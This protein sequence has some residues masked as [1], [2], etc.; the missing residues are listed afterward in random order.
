MSRAETEP[1]PSTC[2]CL[3][4]IGNRVH[5]FGL[6][7]VLYQPTPEF[8][9]NLRKAREVC[10]D[11]IAVDNTPQPDQRLHDSLR[12]AGV[13][14]I[15]NRNAGGLAGA[16]NRGAEALLE[17]GRDVMFLLDQDSDIDESFFDR[18]MSACEAIGA[19]A[20]LVGPT[21]YEKGMDT[22]MPVTPPQGVDPG[23]AP[24]AD[25]AATQ[26]I[27]SSGTAMSAEA[28][29]TLGPFREDY[30]IECVDIEYGLRAWSLGVPV[31]MTSAVTLNQSTGHITRH[32]RHFTTNH[33]AWRR[34]YSVRNTVHATRTY[35]PRPH[36]PTVPLRMAL[37]QVHHVVRFEDDKVRKLTAICWGWIDGMRSRLGSFEERHPKVH[38]FCR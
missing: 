8:V 4:L 11:V 13:E 23:E 24:A 15:V 19:G 25:L 29:R 6:I 7:F 21:I 28:Y 5:T 33:V 20:Y 3:D 16:Y 36:G 38:A 31:F 9:G 35:R 2:P 12:A 17:R 18:M 26:S 10:P 37:G 14:V 1:V 27:I 32:G 34:Y 22:V 30:F